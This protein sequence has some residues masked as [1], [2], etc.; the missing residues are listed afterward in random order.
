MRFLLVVG[1]F[2]HF[3]LRSPL[4]LLVFRQIDFAGELLQCS[5]KRI[6]THCLN[7]QLEY[8]RAKVQLNVQSDFISSIISI[9]CHIE[10]AGINIEPRIHTDKHRVK[11]VATLS[12]L[13]RSSLFP[14][15]SSGKCRQ[16]IH[17]RFRHPAS[18]DTDTS[19]Y[20]VGSSRHPCLLRFLQ[21]HPETGTWLANLSRS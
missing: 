2:G 7:H 3:L 13:A 15:V 4:V 11:D 5:A 20:D 17:G 19:M 21:I 14:G 12:V 6:Q 8:A 9:S 10:R 1:A 16:Y 18:H